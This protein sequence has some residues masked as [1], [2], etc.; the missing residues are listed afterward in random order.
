MLRHVLIRQGFYNIANHFIIAAPTPP[1]GVV[2]SDQTQLIMVQLTLPCQHLM[3]GRYM[4]LNYP[5]LKD[6]STKVEDAQSGDQ[7]LPDPSQEE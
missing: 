1:T 3:T 7:L 5:I 4:P 2:S 6:V